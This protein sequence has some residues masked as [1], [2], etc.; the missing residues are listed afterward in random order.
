MNAG[1]MIAL[2]IVASTA[3]WSVTTAP[4]VAAISPVDAAAQLGQELVKAVQGFP[5]AAAVATVG[6]ASA[7]AV[8]LTLENVALVSVPVVSELK[9]RPT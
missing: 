8:T 7:V 3:T 4:A 6:A 9:T 1:R 2:A 5:A